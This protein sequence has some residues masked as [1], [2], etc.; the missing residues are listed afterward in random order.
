M[1]KYLI[2]CLGALLFG[3]S[4]VQSTASAQAVMVS[5][6]GILEEKNITLAVE[7]INEYGF[8]QEK[9]TQAVKT[10]TKETL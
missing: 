1:K 5:V 8:E 7:L 9:F 6:E 3:L 2:L 4:S 10:F